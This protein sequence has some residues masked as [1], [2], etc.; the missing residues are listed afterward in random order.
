[1]LQL[2]KQF[3]IHLISMFYSKLESIFRDHFKMLFEVRSEYGVMRIT[4]SQINLMVVM[5]DKYWIIS[6][7]Y[8]IFLTNFNLGLHLVTFVIKDSKLFALCNH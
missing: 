8:V 2:F 7:I 5:N 3:N 4:L 1:M 6:H